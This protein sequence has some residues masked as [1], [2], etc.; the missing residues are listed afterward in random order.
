MSAPYFDSNEHPDDPAGDLS[1]RIV[2]Q[3]G[4]GDRLSRI[5]AE[6]DE[7]W[8]GGDSLDIQAVTALL[9]TLEATLHEIEGHVGNCVAL[10]SHIAPLPVG[11]AA[12]HA[13]SFLG[14]NSPVWHLLTRLSRA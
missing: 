14:L 9:D 10:P 12:K 8:A 11:M 4:L 6:L 2:V 13:A 1:E 5:A 3:D 7:S